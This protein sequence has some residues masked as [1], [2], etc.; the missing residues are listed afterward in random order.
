MK[1]ILRFWGEVNSYLGPL[2]IPD[3]LLDMPI[4]NCK[5]VRYNHPDLNWFISENIPRLYDGE[6]EYTSVRVSCGRLLEEHR[7]SAYL[8]FFDATH[9]RLG[10]GEYPVLVFS[11][12]NFT[13]AYNH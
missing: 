11:D 5:S 8:T 10:H 2:D 3:D 9:P 4:E 7:C 13:S 1:V 12:C 6:A